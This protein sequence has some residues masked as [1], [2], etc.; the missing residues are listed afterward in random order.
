[1]AR[2]TMRSKGYVKAK[3]VGWRYELKLVQQE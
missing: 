3:A 1:M 2:N